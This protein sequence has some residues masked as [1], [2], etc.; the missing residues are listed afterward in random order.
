MGGDTCLPVMG[1]VLVGGPWE[2]ELVWVCGFLCGNTLGKW[3]FAAL[4]KCCVLK[5]TVAPMISLNQTR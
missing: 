1:C 4:K 5:P 3:D 2:P